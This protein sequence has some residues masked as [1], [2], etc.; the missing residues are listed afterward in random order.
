MKGKKKRKKNG[1]KQV[2]EALYLPI[3]RPK[4]VELLVE[5][6]LVGRYIYEE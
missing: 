2:V 3:K 5:L 4:C 6:L 1:I